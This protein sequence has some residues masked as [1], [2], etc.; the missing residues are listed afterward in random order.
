MTF[1]IYVDPLTQL[2]NHVLFEDRVEQS[3]EQARRSGEQIAI[4][5]VELDNLR[6]LF[7]THGERVREGLIK[8]VASRIHS[9]IRKSDTLAR[10]EGGEFAI[11][12]RGVGNSM[13]VTTLVQ[14][15]LEALDDPFAVEG[16]ELR[17]SAS[18]GI[19]LLSPDVKPREIMAQ[20][21]HALHMAK[22][23][24][25]RAFRFHDAAV[26]EEL[27]AMVVL[28]DELESA[29]EKEELFLEYQAQVDLSRNQIIAAEALVRWRHPTRGVLG[30]EVFIPVAEDS[31]LIV[32][33]GQWVLEEACR[34]R[35][36]W[37]GTGLND[38]PIAVNVSGIQFQDPGFSDRVVKT[39]EATQLGPGALD[40]EFTESV[41]LRSSEELRGS[42]VQLFDQGVRF[43]LDDFGTGY[44]SL[45]YLR[46]FPVQK[47][48]IAGEFVRDVTSNPEA[49]SIVEAVIGL[50]HMLGLKVVAEE[51]ETE[52]QLE[53]LRDHACDAAQGYLFG[54][55]EAASEF[56]KRLT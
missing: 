17:T 16:L 40:L 1:E 8:G 56:A 25:H 43:S 55:P 38:V 41:L 28:R 52:E 10:L 37:N 26:D 42:L 13:G 2:P 9:F 4:H 36:I 22:E 14:K 51:V 47:L 19:S 29:L 6:G 33:L 30:P 11:I 31:G 3:V 53:F 7:E 32:P 18:V 54:R 49:A 20:A 15:V 39:L 48:K 35:Q 21:E 34:Q 46:A 5:Y 50:G 23:K 24:S 44:S 12:Q 27:Q 45:R